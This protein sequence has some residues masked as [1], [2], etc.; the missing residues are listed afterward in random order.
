MDLRANLRDI[1]ISQ[2]GFVFDPNTGITFS[3]N[4][5]GQLILVRLRD[6]VALSVIE[7]ELRESFELS[8]DDDP[9]RDV[10]EFVRLLR[11]QG[12]IPREEA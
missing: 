10:R 9:A 6:G 3:V 12:I 11:D 5:T 8:E 7:E 2:S 4:A 1:A